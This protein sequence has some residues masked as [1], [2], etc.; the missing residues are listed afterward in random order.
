MKKIIFSILCFVVFSNKVLAV[1]ILDSPPTDTPTPSAKESTSNESNPS[2]SSASNWIAPFVSTAE[3]PIRFTL[4]SV[5]QNDLTGFQTYSLLDVYAKRDLDD[6]S[7]RAEG[8]VRIKKS[9]SNSDNSS[10]PIDL[11]L[12]KVSYLESWLQVSLGRMD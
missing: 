10:F 9:F 8:M 11:R 12:A 1:T 7:I 2:G 4:D 6:Y 3:N 5:F